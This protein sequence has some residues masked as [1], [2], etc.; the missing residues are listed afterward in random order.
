MF[1]AM[2]RSIVPALL[3]AAALLK[4]SRAGPLVN[5]PSSLQAPLGDLAQHAAPQ[6]LHGRFLH[7]TGAPCS[8]VCFLCAIL[9][10]SRYPS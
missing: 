10:R 3:L 8:V 5:G 2:H 7:I 9:T 1:V 4:I 6:H